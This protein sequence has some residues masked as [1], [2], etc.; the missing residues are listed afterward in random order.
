[1]VLDILPTS[2]SFSACYYKYNKHKTDLFQVRNVLDPVR[3]VRAEIRRDVSVS[4][5]RQIYIRFDSFVSFESFAKS[6]SAA[7]ALTQFA[8]MSLNLSVFV[9]ATRFPADAVWQRNRWLQCIRFQ[10]LST[11]R[12]EQTAKNRDANMM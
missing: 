1:M 9:G 11:E 3:S 4:F 2:M 6:D 7:N 8:P 10:A 12:I 5:L